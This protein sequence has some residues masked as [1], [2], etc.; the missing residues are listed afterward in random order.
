[1]TDPNP[2]T[3]ENRLGR[4][5][6]PYLL[7]HKDNPVHWWAWGPEALAEAKRTGKP[8]LLSVGYAACHWCH[9]MAHESFEDAATAADMNALFVN[10]KVDREERPDIDA[11]YMRALHSLGEHGGWPLTMFLDSAARPFWGGTY[12]PPEPRFGRPA[13]RN[14]LAEVARIYREEPD[15]VQFNAGLLVK[16]LNERQEGGAAPDLSDAGL[17]ALIGPMVRAVDGRRGGLAGAP[18]FPQWSY[19]WLLWRLAIRYGHPAALQAVD[20]TLANI[21]QGGIYDHLGGGFARYSVDERWL[22]PHFEK[23]LYDNALLIDLMTEV[24]RETGS[25]LYKTRIEETVAWLRREM[26]ADGGGFAAS[27]DADSEGEEGRFYVWSKVEIEDVLGADD[28]AR[29]CEAYDVTAEGNWEG[30]TILNRLGS[31]ELRAAEEEEALGAMRAKL[32]ERRAGRIRPGWDDKVLADWNGLAIAALAQAARVF[33]RPEWLELAKRAFQFVLAR[34]EKDGRLA[35]SYRDGRASAPATAG[36]YASLVRA[37]LR[38]F[39]ATGDADYLGVAERWV[40]VVDER[41][42]VAQTGGYAFTADDTPDVIVRMRGAHDD[43]TPNANG[44]MI[45]NLAA[46]HLLT[47]KPRDLEWAEAIPKAF[48]ADIVRNTFGHCGLIAGTLDVIAPQQVVVIEPQAADAVPGSSPLARAMLDLSLPGAVEQIAEPGRTLAN[49]ALT[50]KSAIDGK[51]TA[52]ACLG[53][54]CSLPVT[55]PEAL[56]DLLRKQRMV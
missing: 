42:W 53:P 47:G 26:I 33:A 11:I 32:L 27:L 17:A 55:D 40:A 12:F 46:L 16:A 31:L 15:K 39:L 54:Q 35:H 43:A 34:M 48:A 29:F 36:D 20:T 22:V 50:G 2:P 56:L 18:K 28:A 19:F 37:A 9:V 7:Q 13:F 45:S 41:Y 49:P 10:I 14:V 8:I 51:A 5:T 52:Y 24:Y 4:E 30:H 23:M 3:P 38:L 44:L 21:C 1:M 6:S 25:E